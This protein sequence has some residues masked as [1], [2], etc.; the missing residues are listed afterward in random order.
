MSRSP[1]H[2]SRAQWPLFIL[3]MLSKIFEEL[4]YVSE[5]TN[6]DG[7]VLLSTG[8]IG[9]KCHSAWQSGRNGHRVVIISHASGQRG[10]AEQISGR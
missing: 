1:A 3:D 9:G 6:A 7:L 10:A 4:A 8:R 2:Q 5:H